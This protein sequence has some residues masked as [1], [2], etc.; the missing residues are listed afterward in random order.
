MSLHKS[1]TSERHQLIVGTFIARFIEFCQLEST[2][3]CASSFRF[4][5]NHDHD[6]DQINNFNFIK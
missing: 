3:P 5:Q 4:Y 1:G 6:Y 2:S